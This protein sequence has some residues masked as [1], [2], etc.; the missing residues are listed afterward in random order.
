M[1]SSRP[2]AALRRAAS[3]AD[4]DGVMRSTSELG[5]ATLASIQAPSS[6]SRALAKPTKAVRAT[7]PLCRRL[8]H[9]TT[10]NGMMPAARRRAKASVTKPKTVR[11]AP[12]PARS[13]A[14]S[15]WSVTKPSD[16]GST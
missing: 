12:L 2:L 14:T 7:S 15:G 6:G 3:S 1:R 8:S 13:W 11:G 5:K 10:V 16:C 4:T 9:D